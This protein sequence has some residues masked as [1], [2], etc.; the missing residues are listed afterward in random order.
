ME[1]I[2][3]MSEKT[4]DENESQSLF[5]FFMLRHKEVQDKVIVRVDDDG[6]SMD[7]LN[8]KLTEYMSNR[9]W[10]ITEYRLAQQTF[11][12]KKREYS[13]WEESKL[14][15]ARKLVKSEEKGS[16]EIPRWVIDAKVSETYG[17]E[18]YTKIKELDELEIRMDFFKDLK[19]TWVDQKDVMQTLCNNIR[20]DMREFSGVNK[21]K[22]PLSPS[23]ERMKESLNGQK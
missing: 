15:E 4:I 10:A 19:E 9:T 22:Q 14:L 11:K 21:P 13:K 3:K 6:I 20:S 8:I 2:P 5:E 23:L 16:K 17:V 1:Y 18:K 12:D 7:D